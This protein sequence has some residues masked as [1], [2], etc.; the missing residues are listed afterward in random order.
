MKLYSK[1]FHNY[2][3]LAS[4]LYICFVLWALQMFYLFLLLSG[5]AYSVS[6]DKKTKVDSD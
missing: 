4:I 1:H 2:L 6:T 3:F 5:Y